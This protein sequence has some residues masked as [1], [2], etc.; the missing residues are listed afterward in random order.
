[1][2]TENEA[3]PGNTVEAKKEKSLNGRYKRIKA[4]DSA[5]EALLSRKRLSLRLQI[6]TSFF[7]VFLFAVG[8][9]SVLIATNANVEKKLR[10]LEIANDFTVEIIQARRFEKNFFLYNTNLDDALENVYQAKAIF[11]LNI[12]ELEQVLGLDNYKKMVSSLNRY[13]E[14]LEHLLAADSAES[15]IKNKKSG[16]EP[17]EI[18][19][20]KTGRELVSLAQDLMARE[21]SSLSKMLAR[22]RQLHFYSLIFLLVFSGGQRLF[23]GESCLEQCQTIFCLCRADCLRQ[24][25]P[26]DACKT[27]S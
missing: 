2:H 16:K 11:E 14:I 23:P 6:W 22:S 1:M 20:R 3:V 17:M 21:R 18:A 24:L 19:V 8:I 12:G 25:H 7:L 26:R 15:S 5:R 13:G 10:F 9:V 27:L 4:V